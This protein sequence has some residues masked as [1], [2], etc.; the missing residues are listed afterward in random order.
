[1]MSQQEINRCL[2][3]KLEILQQIGRNTDILLRFVHRRD[4]TGMRRLLREQE[5]LIHALAAVQARL[6]E[7]DCSYPV[8]S[9]SLS[10]TVKRLQTG[11]L[12]GHAKLIDEALCE[13]SKIATDLKNIRLR[14]NINSR[15]LGYGAMPR[16][17]RRFNK[18]G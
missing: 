14:R 15:Y 18:R 7:R 8:E 16:P 2:R 3:E 12:A 17:G 6:P 1:M 5:K 13:R 4:M 11:I 9:I 10:H